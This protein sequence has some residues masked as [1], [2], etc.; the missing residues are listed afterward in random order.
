MPKTPLPLAAG[1]L[2][3]AVISLV[4]PRATA[5]HDGGRGYRVLRLADD[6][7]FLVATCDIQADARPGL[8]VLDAHGREQERLVADDAGDPAWCGGLLPAQAALAMNRPLAARLAVLGLVTAP[9]EAPC[10]PSRSRCVAVLQHTFG[11]QIALVEGRATVRHEDIRGKAGF[12]PF[13]V[14]AETAWDPDE[15]WVVVAGERVARVE[16]GVAV[17]EPFLV[18]WER[19]GGPREGHPP[20]VTGALFKW[21]RKQ[22]KKCRFRKSECDGAELAFR[23]VLRHD[24]DDLNAHEGIDAVTALRK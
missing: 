23:H 2:L 16:P 21:G 24:P 6:G 7:R 20:D 19:P 12:G 11:A 9:L 10:S 18:A 4:A 8:L 1:L 15:R 14:R 3:A 22:L 13:A 17:W 5:T